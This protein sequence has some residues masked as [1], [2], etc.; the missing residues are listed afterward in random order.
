MCAPRPSAIGPGHSHAWCGAWPAGARCDESAPN[1]RRV[2]AAIPEHTVRPLPRSPAC[3]LQQGNRIHQRQG[4]SEQLSTTARDQSIWSSRA[5]QSSSAKWIKSQTPAWCQ[6]RTR[7]QHVI[8][9]PHPSSC[10]SICQGMPLRRTN[11]MPVRHARSE[12]QRVSP[13]TSRTRPRCAFRCTAARRL[14]HARSESRIHPVASLFPRARSRAPSDRLPAGR[15]RR[16]AA[17]PR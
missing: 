11:R 1:G 10:G 9:D 8:P 2:V 15:W 5:S 14:S 13:D 17:P 3:A 4:F 7:R 6:S 16:A 12:T